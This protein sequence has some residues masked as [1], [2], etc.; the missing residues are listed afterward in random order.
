MTHLDQLR[1]ERM[2]LEEQFI[3][4]LGQEDLEAVL[5][6]D[7]ALG[8][9]TKKIPASDMDYF[10][11]GSPLE[12][13]EGASESTQHYLE[14]KL[15]SGTPLPELIKDTAYA[16]KNIYGKSF[17]GQDD[18]TEIYMISM[19]CLGKEYDRIEESIKTLDD[20]G[21]DILG[22]VDIMH[23]EFFEDYECEVVHQVLDELHPGSV[24]LEDL[25]NR[26]DK[27]SEVSEPDYDPNVLYLEKFR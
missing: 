17:T 6:L 10:W 4:S 1:K 9:L 12:N 20:L 27:F 26:I 24:Y 16:I 15:L 21:A 23:E 8:N 5:R 22:W 11:S 19:L 14:A 13:E 7:A 18:E 25:G 3:D 2:D